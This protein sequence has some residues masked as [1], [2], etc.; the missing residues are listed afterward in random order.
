MQNFSPIGFNMKFSKW[1]SR[2]HLCRVGH[3][4]RFEVKDF[5]SLGYNVWKYDD[6]IV[7]NMRIDNAQY[8]DVIIYFPS[9]LKSRKNKQAYQNKFRADV[10]RYLKLNSQQAA[11][12]GPYKLDGSCS[13]LRNDHWGD[14]SINFMLPNRSSDFQKKREREKIDSFVRNTGR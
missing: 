2:I 7:L 9:R 1:W 8:E 14:R 12:S 3:K 4:Q 11:I 13:L 5:G 10:Q 6:L